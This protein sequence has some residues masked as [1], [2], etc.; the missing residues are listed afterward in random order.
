MLMACLRP[1]AVNTAQ[2]DETC[3]VC[4]AHSIHQPVAENLFLF[5]VGNK[6]VLWTQET[7]AL[8]TFT[9]LGATADTIIIPARP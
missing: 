6:A 9:L 8:L 3:P 5:P 2:E 7:E 1:G 4:P